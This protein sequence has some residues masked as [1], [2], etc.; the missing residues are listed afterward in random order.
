MKRLLHLC[1]FIQFTSPLLAQHNVTVIIADSANQSGI[2]NASSSRTDSRIENTAT[3]V[4]VIGSEEVEEESG[5]KPSHIANLVGDVAGIQSQQTSAVTFNTDLRVQGLP[6]DYLQ[7][8]RDG[9]P[10]FGGY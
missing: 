4:E 9:L 10:L 1:I 8:L 6:G 7:L 3:R 5:V 2:Q